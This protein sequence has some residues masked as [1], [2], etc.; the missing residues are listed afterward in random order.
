MGSNT[1]ASITEMNSL[2]NEN[3]TYHGYTTD[4]HHDRRLKYLVVRCCYMN[5]LFSSLTMKVEIP[6][7]NV[8]YGNRSLIWDVVAKER[9]Y[10]H[11]KLVTKRKFN[12]AFIIVLPKTTLDNLRECIHK[13]YVRIQTTVIIINDGSVGKRFLNNITNEAAI[14]DMKCMVMTSDGVASFIDSFVE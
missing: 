7:V 10:V 3:D 9:D 4:M 14:Y 5:D 11:H 12:R 13:V 8:Y 2:I 6:G 1:S